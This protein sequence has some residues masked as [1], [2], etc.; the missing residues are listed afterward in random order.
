MNPEFS[1]FIGWLYQH[2]PETE[3]ARL[4]QAAGETLGYS[5]NPDTQE[6]VTEWP[7]LR[8]ALDDFLLNAKHYHLDRIGAP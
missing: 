5:L 7:A 1:A 3:Q 2:L 8:T 4:E 6:V